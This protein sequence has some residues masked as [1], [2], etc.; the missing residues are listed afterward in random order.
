MQ[1][2]DKK[3]KLNYIYILKPREFIRTNENIYKIGRTCQND[4]T[5]IK[6]Y[7]KGSELI[8]FRK[9][10]DCIKVEA[11]LIKELKIKYTHMPIY[12]NEYF[13]GNELDII[14]DVNNI[15]DNETNLNIPINLL[16]NK[17]L[18]IFDK[19]LIYDKIDNK[20]ESPEIIIKKIIKKDRI[21]RD[22]I[23]IDDLFQ[24]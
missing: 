16:D 8:L 17:E 22:T 5:R 9:C 21:K 7:P 3:N 4:M 10:I 1:I 18:E 19:T 11:C 12:G 24:D 20:I 2:I 13:E 6:Q 14:K 15:I 23:F